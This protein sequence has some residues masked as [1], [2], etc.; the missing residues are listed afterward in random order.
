MTSAHFSHPKGHSLQVF[1]P[2][3]Y[4]D[5]PEAVLPQT[6]QS[7]HDFVVG[8]TK[9]VSLRTLFEAQYGAPF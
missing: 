8:G 6:T 3:L 1:L 5:L 2:S 7:R 4:W 9:V